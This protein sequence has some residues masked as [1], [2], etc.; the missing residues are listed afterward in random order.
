[1]RY[2]LCVESKSRAQ[3][4]PLTKQKQTQTENRLAVAKVGQGG[5]GTDWEFGFGKC[6]LLY[7]AWVSSE[8]L[9]DSPGNYIQSLGIDNDGRKYMKGNVYMYDCVILLYS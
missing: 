1:M 5:S 6:K 3:I 8:V 4:N 7:L 9:L 2:H